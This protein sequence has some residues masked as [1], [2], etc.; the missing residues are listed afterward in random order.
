[1]SSYSSSL[2]TLEDFKQTPLTSYDF[3]LF[4]F[5]PHRGEPCTSSALKC[6][7]KQEL[8]SPLPSLKQEYSVFISDEGTLYPP[9]L[10]KWQIPLSRF[11]LIKTDGATQTWKASLEALQ[12]GLFRW[13]FLRPS[14]PCNFVQVRKLQLE[15]EKRKASVFLFSKAKFPHWLFKKR[16]ESTSSLEVSHDPGFITEN[17]VFSKPKTAYLYR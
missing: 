6:L 14:Q 9:A 2:K 5:N 1:M 3:G 11:L 17:L 12:T 13:V 4:L 15:A 7:Q 16:L 10:Q 8:G